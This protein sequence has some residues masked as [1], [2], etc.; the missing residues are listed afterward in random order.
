MTIV[1]IR[2]IFVSNQ[3]PPAPQQRKLTLDIPA[4]LSATYSNAVIITQTHSEIV[5]DFLQVMPNDPRARVQSRIVMTPMHAK[6]LLKALNTNLERYEEKHGEI[7]T[8]QQPPSLAE[9]LFGG[10]KPET[11]DD[12]SAA[13]NE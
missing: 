2:G 1:I 6:L 9:Q 10:F 3:Q 8:P 12:G 5:F 7:Q 4:N 13:T 11:T